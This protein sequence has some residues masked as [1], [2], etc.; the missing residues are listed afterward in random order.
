ML[1]LERFSTAAD[2]G[3]PLS[4]GCVAAARLASRSTSLTARQGELGSVLPAWQ[5]AGGP[6][7]LVPEAT[8]Q[9][10]LLVVTW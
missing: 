4:C 3:I 10:L 7:S 8:A 9:Q 1:I 6:A 2:Q 5:G